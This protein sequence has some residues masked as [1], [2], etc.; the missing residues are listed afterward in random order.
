MVYT[1]ISM[2]Y[3]NNNNNNNK[4][5]YSNTTKMINLNILTQLYG[6][7]QRAGT[8]DGEPPSIIRFLIPNLSLF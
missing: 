5:Q 4:P 7:R 3:N 6:A 1:I 8:N 2:V